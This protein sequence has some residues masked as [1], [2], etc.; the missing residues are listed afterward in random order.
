MVAIFFV[1]SGFSLSYKSLGL[2]REA[3]YSEVL[4]SLSSSVLRRGT[5]LYVPPAVTTFFAMLASYM[6]WYG[7]GPGS[8][9]PPQSP[10]LSE[11]LLSWWYSV[12]ELSDP[13]RPAIF[14]GGYNPPYDTNL[15]TIPVEF[16]GS[17]VVF[18]VLLGLAKTYKLVRV[19]ALGGL[20][21]YLL[22]FAHSHLFLFI[23]GAFLAALH[24]EREGNLNESQS[25]TLDQGE[26]PSLP[27]WLSNR[28]WKLAKMI[29]WICS[30]ICSLWV[31]SMPN[32]DF[33]GRTTPG[34]RV[35]ASMLPQRYRGPYIENNFWTYIA[36]VCLVFIMDNFCFFQ[37]IFT[38]R[39]AQFL[40]RIS[41]GLYIVHG[42]LLYTL[43]WNVSAKALELTGSEPGLPYASGILLTAVLLYPLMF[44][45]ADVVA[46]L[47]DAESVTFARW[48]SAKITVST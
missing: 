16:Y 34:Y 29:F 19:V 1:I 2:M 22:Y 48:L 47:V 14:P 15:W 4:A 38:T 3:R 35:L 28:N 10:Y 42:T 26:K 30:F 43:G 17:M 45:T 24:H 44:W 25:I 41:F 5:R 46:R 18:A 40:G 31:L 12:I 13:F 20:V 7:V 23:S 27:T 21:I 11:H 36:A 9:Q 6:G 33:G 39:F 37:S 8:R 32:M